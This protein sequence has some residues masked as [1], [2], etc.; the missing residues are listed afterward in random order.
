[1]HFCQKLTRL[2]ASD[3]VQTHCILSNEDVA[4]DKVLHFIVPPQQSPPRMMF[5]TIRQGVVSVTEWVG[6]WD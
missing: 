1:M 4:L 5:G 6:I 2:H 3:V